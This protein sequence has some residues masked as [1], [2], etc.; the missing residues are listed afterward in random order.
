MAVRLVCRRRVDGCSG[1]LGMMI[2]DV[3]IVDEDNETSWL[4]RQG[5]GRDQAVLGV[6]AVDPDYG[7]ASVYL[8]VDRATAGI[9]LESSSFES[10]DVHQE[11]L[12]GLHV[13]VDSQRN[14][15]L[16]FHARTLLSGWI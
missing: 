16:G 1:A 11:S 14:D 6:D 3:H 15:G 8:G 7:V 2:V 13:L 10:E 12:C 4:R 5:P 9:S